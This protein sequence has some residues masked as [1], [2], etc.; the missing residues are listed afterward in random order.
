[1]AVI[2]RAN[3]TRNRRRDRWARLRGRPRRRRSHPRRCGGG[4][5]TPSTASTCSS[6]TPACPAHR[7]AARDHDRRVGR[8]LRRQHAGDADR[9]PDGRRRRMIKDATGGSIVNLASMGGK[10]GAAGSGPLRGVEGGGDLAHPGRRARARARTASA[11][12]P[13]VRA[14][15]SPR[16]APTRARRRWSRRGAPRS[17][18]G[19]FAEPADVANMALFL[20]SGDSDYCTGQAFNVTGGM[21]MH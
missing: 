6:T 19:R 1:M 4:R 20:A 18:L 16:W 5:S 15:C 17:P 8:H 7:S 21:I 14:T 13:S 9:H 2:D 11:S 10:V 12:T 3:A